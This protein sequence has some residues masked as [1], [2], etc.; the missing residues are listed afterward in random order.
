MIQHSEELKQEALQ[1]AP[2]SG[3]SC[4]QVAADLRSD[5]STVRQWL[6]DYRPSN[7]VLAPQANLALANE[8]RR[9]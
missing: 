6:V 5:K 8:R 1:I 9:L 4:A 7:Q 2:T 3:L